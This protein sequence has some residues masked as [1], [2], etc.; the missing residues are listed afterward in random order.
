MSIGPWSNA[1]IVGRQSI[2]KRGGKV[3][4]DRSDSTQEHLQER[5]GVGISRGKVTFGCSNHPKAAISRS[6]VAIRVF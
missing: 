2:G 1:G 6:R 4:N 3:R 5:E